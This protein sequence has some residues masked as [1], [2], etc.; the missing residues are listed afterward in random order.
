MYEAILTVAEVMQ[1]CNTPLLPTVW[2]IIHLLRH[3]TDFES[4]ML[5]RVIFK[6]REFD[7][8]EPKLVPCG[9]PF[10]G[11]LVNCKI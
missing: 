8:P 7:L 2:L 11:G 4:Y 10:Q 9:Q 5:N 6:L 3:L 1:V